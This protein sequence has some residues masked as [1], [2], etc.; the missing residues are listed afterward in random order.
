MK[1]L[2]VMIGLFLF[3]SPQI[4]YAET[5]DITQ[6]FSNVAPVGELSSLQ[7]RKCVLDG[8]T[9]K[10]R[11]KKGE[12]Y[13]EFPFEKE[14]YVYFSSFVLNGSP[15][16]YHDFIETIY[17]RDQIKVKSMYYEKQPVKTDQLG[18]YKVDLCFTD[19]NDRI[20]HYK[21]VP[22]LVTSDKPTIYFSEVNFNQKDMRL[23]GRIKRR[24]SKYTCRIELFYTDNNK[25]HYQEVKADKAGNFLI[26]LSREGKLGEL[27]LRASDGLGNY[28]DAYDIETEGH[29]T[30]PVPKLSTESLQAMPVKQ[31]TKRHLATIVKKIALGLAMLFLI[32]AFLKLRRRNK[33]RSRKV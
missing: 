26:D 23:S 13:L 15:T 24:Q 21:N 30:I 3:L 11:K 32:I 25:Y 17:Y 18:I 20:Y 28:A 5:E 9:T 4:S 8:K 27:Y 29:Q 19:E 7:G 1:N 10:K 31:K 33:K 16:Q 6:S 22:Y 2:L 12:Y 14:P